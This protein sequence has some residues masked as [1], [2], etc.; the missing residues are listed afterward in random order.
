MAADQLRA[1]LTEPRLRHVKYLGLEG[2]RYFA[3]DMAFVVADTMKDLLHVDLRLT[4]V[5]GCGVKRLVQALPQLKL[6]NLND[7]FD[8][9]SDAVDWARSQG[10]TV[11]FQFAD[12]R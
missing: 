11:L 3:D 8:V 9:N 7:C 12:R 10:I 2:S 6:L 4:R 5:T 1:I